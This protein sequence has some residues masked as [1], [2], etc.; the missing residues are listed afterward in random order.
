MKIYFLVSC[1]ANAA[2]FCLSVGIFCRLSTQTKRRVIKTFVEFSRI[3]QCF[4]RLPSQPCDI[5]KCRNFATKFSQRNIFL[6]ISSKKFVASLALSLSLM[7][8]RLFYT[9]KSH[10]V[11][12]NAKSDRCLQDSTTCSHAMSWRRSALLG[13]FVNSSLRFL[14]LQINFNPKRD[15]RDSTITMLDGIENGKE[16][17]N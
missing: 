13:K 4:K 11:I 16:K 15:V 5:E 14:L 9:E 7:L 10:F 12:Q 8:T 3:L 1:V 6:T 17:T 2:L